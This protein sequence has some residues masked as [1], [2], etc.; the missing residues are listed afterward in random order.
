VCSPD[1]EHLRSEIT[2]FPSQDFDAWLLFSLV[3]CFSMIVCTMYALLYF[4]SHSIAWLYCAKRVVVCRRH[5]HSNYLDLL[6]FFAIYHYNYSLYPIYLLVT[7]YITSI[8]YLTPHI[9][10]QT[11][12]HYRIYRYYIIFSIKHYIYYLQPTFVAITVPQICSLI[13]SM[14]HFIH[15]RV[16]SK[17]D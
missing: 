9:S 15:I 12:D 14:L 17:F 4:F 16:F 7:H 1:F 11:S 2:R 13:S 6:I 10:L 5:A 8:L 3:I